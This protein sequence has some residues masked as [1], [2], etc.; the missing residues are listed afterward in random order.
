LI[1]E[2]LAAAGRTVH[3]GGNIGRPLIDRVEF[4]RSTD[5][6]VLE[7]SS[8]QLDRLAHSPRFAVITNI[9][10]NHLQEHGSFE[11]YIA[12][13][14]E[15]FQHQGPGD[16]VVLNLDNDVTRGFAREAPSRV[17]TFSMDEASGAD[18]V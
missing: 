12:A 17:R 10:P 2:M 16:W 5:W 9:T 18:V 14:K 8:F 1:G 6:V 7:L 4:I 11:A 13:K 3:V 15:I